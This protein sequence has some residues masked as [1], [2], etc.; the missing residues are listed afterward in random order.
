LSGIF[1]SDPPIEDT[2]YYL[3][4]NYWTWG[5]DY[6]E[7][8]GNVCVSMPLLIPLIGFHTFH[9]CFDNPLSPDI[10]GNIFA[11][12]PL[13][14]TEDRLGDVKIKAANIGTQSYSSTFRIISS[15]ISDIR[16][17][18]LYVPHMEE[19]TQLADLL[20][21]T[22]AYYGADTDSMQNSGFIPDSPYC[23]YRQVRSNPG[24]ELFAGELG[25][26]ITY[27]AQIICTFYNWGN[28]ANDTAGNL[29]QNLIQGGS[30]VPRVSHTYC[31]SYYD[32]YDC[33]GGDVCC[34]GNIQ[35]NPRP[36]APCYPGFANSRCVPLNYSG[37][38]TDC[39]PTDLDLCG[40]PFKCVYDSLL[41]SPP[42]TLPPQT[43]ACTNVVLVNM[44]L[45][46]RTPLAERAWSKLVAG[47][48]GIFRRIFPQIGPNSDFEGIIDMPASTNVSYQST[49][50]NDTVYAGNP[51]N[52]I[53]G[54]AAQLYFPHIGGIKEY[55]LTGMQTL[56]RP[57]GM[58]DQPVFCS[59]DECVQGNGNTSSVGDSETPGVDVCTQTCTNSALEGISNPLPSYIY[60]NFVRIRNGWF[61]DG[62][63]TPQAPIL[64]QYQTVVDRAYS[65][66]MNP[67]FALAIWLNESVASNYECLCEERGLSEIPDFGYN[68][69]SLKTHFTCPGG[70]VTIPHFNEQ[71]TN[72]LR[73]PSWYQQ[74]CP[75]NNFACPWERFGAL[76]YPGECSASDQGNAYINGIRE[77][78][79][80]LAPGLAFPCYP[81]SI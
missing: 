2:T 73:L 71:L 55:F 15:Q 75:T 17:A 19:G 79:G 34:S 54:S 40:A 59:G 22:Y 32:Q 31:D 76:F 18:D 81:I 37:Q 4:E 24:D 25:A 58:G 60:D 13:S 29:C 78:Y 66:G 47:S 12:V 57:K 38:G 11:Y 70:T 48:A 74:L 52:R 42:I 65:S 35:E 64:D 23:E 53:P 10:F 28:P 27:T 7:W 62:V 67:V 41:C 33:G 6:E 43:Q 61:G 39:D 49:D 50:P 44:R 21:N 69:S 16:N 80:W 77:I 9:L 51:N 20:Q 26:N 8:R 1:R 46:T 68:I 30:C 3:G 56:L 36:G 63:C 5:T 45:E 72:F 14:S